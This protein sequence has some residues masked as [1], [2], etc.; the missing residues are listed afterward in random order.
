VSAELHRSAQGIDVPCSKGRVSCS[1]RSAPLATKKA[2]L[3]SSRAHEFSGMGF[4]GPLTFMNFIDILEVVGRRRGAIPESDFLGT[5][6]GDSRQTRFVT[7]WYSCHEL[8]GDGYQS[9][10]G[11][12]QRCGRAT[13]NGKRQLMENLRQWF[14]LP[15][16]W[17]A[18]WYK[19]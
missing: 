19:A 5:H 16:V 7:N 13:T 9:T 11:H 10:N 17:D 12:S 1:P 15:A 6:C 2:P 8:G 4:V 18:S 14:C 3:E